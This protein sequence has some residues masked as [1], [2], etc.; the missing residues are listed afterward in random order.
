VTD[1]LIVGF[2]D[3]DFASYVDMV[4]SMGTSSGA[5]RDLALAFIPL[6]GR[7]ARALDVLTAYHFE[8]REGPVRPFHNTDFLWP[9]ITYLGS[10]LERRGFSVDY[11]NLFHLE[12]D[13][14]RDKLARGDVLTVAVTTTLYVI[15][16]P[17]LDVV[18]F[19][20]ACDPRVRI[21]V[22]GPYVRNQTT[23]GDP[24][25]VRRV[26]KFI[27]ADVYVDSSEG[28]AA[29][30]RV[31]AALRDGRSL[32]GID[33][34]A[35][36]RGDD[37][38]VNAASVESNALVENPVDYRRFARFA[39]DL[40]E[41][42]SLR[43]AKSCPF[44]C[45]F[46]GFPGRAGSYTYLPVEL[47]ER[48]LDA[49]R[50]LGTVTTLTFLDDTFNVPKRR[51]KDIL[52]MMIRNRYGFRWNSFYRSDHGDEEA[53]ALMAESGCEGV[54]LG[55]ESGSAAML[56]R[57][58]KT[59][60]PDDYLR[61]IPRLRAA[62][63]S[64]YASLIVGYPGETFETVRETMDFI[65]ATRPD[66][67]RAQLWYADHQT[68]IWKDRE[69]WRIEGEGFNWRHATMDSATASDLV[70][71]MFLGVR[72]A[73]WMPQYGFEQWSTFYL[74]RRGM[75]LPQ[76]KTFLRCFNEVIKDRL[77]RPERGEPDPALME[78][79]RRSCRFDRPEIASVIESERFPAA[80]YGAAERFWTGVFREP[81]ASVAG[82]LRDRAGTGAPVWDEVALRVDGALL[83]SALEATGASLADVVLAAFTALL[84]RLAGGEDVA[85][86]ADG[87]LPLRLRPAWD[88]GFRA[89][90]GEVREG[91]ARA[92][93]HADYAAAIV[94]NPV[95][96]REAGARC[97]ALEVSCAVADETPA[98]AEGV[99]LALRG[100]ARPDGVEL[101][102]GHDGHWYTRETAEGVASCL[103]ALLQEIARDV[104]V[105]IGALALGA[106]GAA[107][108]ATPAARAERET[109]GAERETFDFEGSA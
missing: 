10:F 79:L 90:L 38:V 21:V 3:Y 93:A 6:G 104:D 8:G 59:A 95:R 101:R 86:L 99:R 26:F 88:R 107:R 75:T 18:A 96:M 57:M 78:R 25:A 9:T 23:A 35:Y 58:N 16:E 69:A 19:V 30:A 70:E 67:F 22:G 65:D 105:P 72:G 98:P 2:N 84:A 37:Y 5:Y 17:I 11:V 24:E 94:M 85:I 92:R 100:V 48:E 34:V 60:R 41:F 62:G 71:Q 7:P 36:R 73:L 32:D 76:I 29:L 14:L 4:A 31:L 74:Q 106:A 61:A 54:F 91:V 50:E 63:I 102:L 82:V 83:A 45:A 52:R 97:P 43:T 44:A 53:I 40:G 1:C 46:C 47:V 56:E 109:F 64:T 27:G 87:V 68:P 15:P 28:E 66:F 42:V 39:A 51:F 55:V 49:L 20:R 12:R 81:C 103:L 13:R 108:G 80:A 77:L 89:Y 33:N